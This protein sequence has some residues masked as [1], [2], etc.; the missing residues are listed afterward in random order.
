MGHELDNYPFTLFYYCH[1]SKDLI[2]LMYYY[3]LKNNLWQQKVWLFNS[4]QVCF[5]SVFTEIRKGENVLLLKEIIV[6]KYWENWRY[7]CS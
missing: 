4:G 7:K 1:K 2:I 5:G 3:C 6:W